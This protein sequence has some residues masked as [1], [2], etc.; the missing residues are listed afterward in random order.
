[1]N[2]DNVWVV[3]GANLIKQLIELKKVNKIIIFTIPIFLGDGIKLFDNVNT[4]VTLKIEDVVHDSNYISNLQVSV[5]ITH[6]K[7]T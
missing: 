3:G 4:N 5:L 2:L 6:G 7:R 1:M